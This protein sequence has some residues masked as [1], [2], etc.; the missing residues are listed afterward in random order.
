MTRRTVILTTNPGI[1]DIVAEEARAR[2]GAEVVEIRAGHGRVIVDIDE[3]SLYL[4]EY[5]RSIHR[6]KLLLA[7]DK[8]CGSKECLSKVYEVVASSGVEKYV[9]PYTS[10]AIRAERV[11]MHEYSSLDIARVA[12]D[13][14]IDAVR[15]LY[16]LRPPVD[17]DY[18]AVAVSVD[19][20]ND[21][22][23]VSIELGGELSWHRRGYRIYD[24][25]AALK[26]TLA[27]AMVAMSGIVDGE[28]LM[29]PMCG[30]GTV[31]IEAAQLLEHSRIICMDRSR[32]HI[33]GARLNARAAMVEN[34]IRFIVG[35]ATRLSS[36]VDQVDVV[37]SN[38][39]YGIRM[40]SPHEVRRVYREFLREAASVVRKS[41]VLITTEHRVVKRTLEEHG[42]RIVHERRVAHGNLYPYIIVA[43]PR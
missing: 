22:I 21:E 34:R 12:G 15:R 6:A 20:I 4:V 42:W 16:G 43:K 11:G 17:L 30:G 8:I 28:T 3:S 7:R 33:A 2:L 41:I 18:P 24:H 5:M 25:P 31:A 1:E 35:D 19:V 40:G 37:V 9:T 27:Y 14:V 26:P 29:D 39:P 10:F 38:P 32:R 13:A 23:Y 36:Y